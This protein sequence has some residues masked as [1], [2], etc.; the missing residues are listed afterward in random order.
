MRGWLL[1]IAVLIAGCGGVDI[2]SPSPAPQ[3][4]FAVLPDIVAGI[5]APGEPSAVVGPD[6]RRGGW[7][8][9][10]AQEL[11]LGHCGLASPLDF[12]GSLWDPVG[13]HNGS[14]GQLTE[15]QVGDLI[16]SSRV[17]I[18]LVDPDTALLVTRNGAVVLIERHQGPRPIRLCD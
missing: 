15:A 2:P 5:P 3:P 13:G 18:R 17:S 10:A 16:N 4:S 1:L 8:I 7:A 14:G 6:S 11:T 9:G 12:D